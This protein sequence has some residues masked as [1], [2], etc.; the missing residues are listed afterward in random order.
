MNLYDFAKAYQDDLRR[1]GNDFRL[2]QQT[3]PYQ[4]ATRDRLLT[5]LGNA[6]ISLGVTIKSWRT[7]AD[8]G[9]AAK[10]SHLRV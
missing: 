6:L 2:S 7:R 9:C 10:A 5:I 3:A 1:Q 8:L 4:L